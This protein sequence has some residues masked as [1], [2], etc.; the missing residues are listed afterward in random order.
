M[1]LNNWYTFQQIAPETQDTVWQAP[2]TRISVGISGDVSGHSS[3]KD[4]ETITTSK[5]EDVYEEN[6][7]VYLRTFSGS[8][9][10]LGDPKEDYEKFAPNSKQRLLD[11]FAKRRASVNQ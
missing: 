2:E 1:K 8:I 3:F 7:I 10:E 11:S 4:G 9:Y 5:P 6:G